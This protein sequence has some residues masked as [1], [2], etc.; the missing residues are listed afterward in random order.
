VDET[1]LDAS[2]AD[3]VRRL[4]RL[5][6]ALAAPAYE[7]LLGAL[8]VDIDVAEMEQAGRTK[9][10]KSVDAVRGG[11]VLPF[12]ERAGVGGESPDPGPQV[13]PSST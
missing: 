13:P 12:P 6:R 8:H 11:A 3:V 4:V 1:V 7:E 9:P 5:R 2:F 10:R